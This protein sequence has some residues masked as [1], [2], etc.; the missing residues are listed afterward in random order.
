MFIWKWTL[1]L[2]GVLLGTSVRSEGSRTGQ[3]EKSSCGNLMKPQSIINP[4]RSF[5]AEITASEFFSQP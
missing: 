1:A 4:T 3:K 5:N 2:L